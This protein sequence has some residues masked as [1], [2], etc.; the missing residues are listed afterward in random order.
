[1]GNLRVQDHQPRFFSVGN[2]AVCLRADVDTGEVT[3]GASL[4]PESADDL[5]PHVL[6]VEPLSLVLG[7]A[8]DVGLEVVPVLARAGVEVRRPVTELGERSME[9]AGYVPGDR[10]AEEDALCAEALVYRARRDRWSGAEEHRPCETLGERP[11]PEQWLLLVDACGLGVR[12]VDVGVDDRLPRVLQ[13]LGQLGV[14][15]RRGERDRAG[16][17]Q[18]R[19]VLASPQ[20]VDHGAHQSQHATGALEPLQRRP[21]LV[22]SV[23]QLRVNRVGPLDAVLVRRVAG[24][25]REVVGV[26]AVHLDICSRGSA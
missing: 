1:M 23:E 10:G 19:G 24:L 25:T 14:H 15:V 9:V 13:V 7:C 4:T 5:G 17:D 12:P 26:L 11:L 21:L 16:H 8:G 6:L 2:V 22:E 18:W 20:R 3:A